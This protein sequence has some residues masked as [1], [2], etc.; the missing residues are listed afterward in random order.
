M[1]IRQDA[2]SQQY[3]SLLKSILLRVAPIN[4]HDIH[5]EKIN[6]HVEFNA[7]DKIDCA[8]SKYIQAELD[9][10]LSQDRCIKGHE[11]IETNPIWQRISANNYVNSNYGWCVFSDENGSQYK[12]V[13]KHLNNDLYTKHATIIYTRPSIHE[14]YND[15][16]HATYDM[17]CTMYTDCLVRYNR[18]DYI[19]HQRSSD[20]WNGLRNDLAWH[21]FMFNKILD[22]LNKTHGNSILPGMIYFNIDSC[23]IYKCNEQQIINYLKESE[24]LSED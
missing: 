10:Y 21:Q 3:R 23:H 13:L 2:N 1:I 5:F 17:M 7:Y 4:S 20:A 11:L 19:V 6:T 18:L 9:W 24:R 15:G 8:S 16:K 12:H 22:D 14:E